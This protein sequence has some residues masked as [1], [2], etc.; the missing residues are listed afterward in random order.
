[1]AFFRAGDAISGQE[2]RAY[3]TIA[4]RVEELFYAKTIEAT[5]EKNKSEF[6]SLGRRGVQS[7]AIG[8]TGTG[9]M[10]IYYATPTFRQMMLDY[11]KTGKDTY[12]DL[13]IVNEDPNST[14]GK[15]TVVLRNVN[16]NSVIMAKLD[17]DAEFLEED[18]DFTFDDVDIQDSFTMPVMG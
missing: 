17:V 13:Q 15:Q 16:L 3:A 10:T 2:G 5:A 14:L 12:F 7:K 4:G 1:M 6:K 9:S 11:I 8:W 18:I